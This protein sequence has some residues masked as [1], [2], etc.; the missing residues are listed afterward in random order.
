MNNNVVI[1][2]RVQMTN[3]A[4]IFLEI[5]LP[6]FF[7]IAVGALLQIKF[8][9]DLYTLAKINIYYLSPALIFSKLYESSF[10][11][12]LFL[13]VIVF[14]A[15]FVFILYCFGHILGKA[16][17]LEKKQN[18]TFSHSIMFYNSGNYGI[19]VNDLVFKQDPL[20]MSIQ[21]AVMAFQNTLLFSYGVFAL[22]SLNTGKLKALLAY[23]K[24]PLFYAMFL[25]ISFNLLHVKLPIFF[26]TPIQYVSNSLIAIAL[27]TL[28]AQIANLKLRLTYAPL[29]VSMATRLLIGPLLAFIL[30]KLFGIDGMV[31]QALLISTAMPTS[32][33]SSIIAQEYNNEPEFA[34]QTV[35]TSTF[36]SSLTLTVVIYLALAVF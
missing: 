1:K 33:N 16:M 7:L 18:M 15:I 3:I 17:K 2:G 30:L 31:A 13:G 14:T 11:L 23:F 21:I 36:F 32:V 34:A 5:I 26:I 28:G 25:G 24:M 19:P 4:F 29:Y 35:I 8:K 20:A 12:K 6:I 27:L 22:N 10:S 9:L